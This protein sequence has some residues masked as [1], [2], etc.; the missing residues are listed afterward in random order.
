MASAFDELEDLAYHQAKIRPGTK[1]GEI[2]DGQ[3]KTIDNY[4]YNGVRRNPSV[5]ANDPRASKYLKDDTTYEDRQALAQKEIA[6]GANPG[7][8]WDDFGTGGFD[9]GATEEIP[10]EEQEDNNQN[11]D[12]KP[13]EEPEEEAEPEREESEG[14]D[15]ENSPEQVAQWVRPESC[16]IHY[17]EVSWNNGQAKN[18]LPV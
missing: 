1:R 13:D 6:Q 2:D 18:V 11:N 10:E 3:R 16:A 7:G 14:S 4:I 9:Q 17:W 15:D 8:I 12:R 5:Y